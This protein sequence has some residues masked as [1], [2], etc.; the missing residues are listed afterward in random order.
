MR[1]FWADTP[2]PALTHNFQFGHV[3]TGG[4]SGRHVEV[5][6]VAFRTH[7][8]HQP[9]PRGK[10]GESVQWASKANAYLIHLECQDA[11]RV[12]AEDLF[13][14]SVVQLGAVDP[15]PLHGSRV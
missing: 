9:L 5:E 6:H 11:N 14:G 3:T 2:T 12:V 13:L 15:G 8:G 7:F 1:G 4:F 10:A